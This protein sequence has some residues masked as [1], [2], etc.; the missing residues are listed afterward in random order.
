MSKHVNLA[1]GTTVP[2]SG[3]YKCE[4]CGP[5]G[6]MAVFAK[7]GFGNAPAQKTVAVYLKSGDKF[8]GCPNCGEA[9]GWS[10]TKS[11]FEK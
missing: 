6:A 3:K 4:M 2:Q 9:A 1:P 7:Q 5:E 11:P 10:L 8:P